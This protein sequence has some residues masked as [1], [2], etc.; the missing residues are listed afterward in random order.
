MIWALFCTMVIAGVV[1]AGTTSKQAM[2]KLASADFVAQGQSEAVANAGLTDAYAWFRRQ[3]VQPVVTFAP[4]R[5]L[6]ASPPVNETDDPAVGLVREY[7]VMPSL[8]ARYEVLPGRTAE[9]FTDSNGDGRYGVGE[10]FVDANGNGRRDPDRETLDVSVKRGLSG[11]GGAWHVVS[12]GYIYRRPRADLPLT[13]APNVRIASTVTSGEIRRLTITPPATSALCVR[14]AS[15]ANIGSRSRVLGGT[16]GGIIS[17]SST[18]S[19]TISTSAEVAG[20]PRV[21]T[22]SSYLDSVDNIYGVTLTELKGMADASYTNP[23]TV[24]GTMGDYTLTVVTGNVTFDATR[25]LR[26]TGVLVVVGN[27]TIAS[28][29]NSFFNGVLH[30]TGNLT[31]R[32]PSYVRGTIVVTGT[33]DVSGTGGDYVEVDYDQNIVVNLLTLMGQYRHTMAVY[34]AAPLLADGTPDELGGGRGSGGMGLGGGLLG[35]LLGGL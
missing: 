18:G 10:P 8:W 2:D 29:S 17:K 1:L 7:E 19:P 15:S 6:A 31:L 23:A 3:T 34:P 9:T 20:T 28:G 12:H 21:G 5:D 25:P 22:V 4:R 33:C 32:G 30:V 16:K 35:G 27:C 26:G 13:T 14:T 11:S 24:P